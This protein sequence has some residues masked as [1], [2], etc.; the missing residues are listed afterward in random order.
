MQDRFLIDL[1][2]YDVIIGYRADDSYFSFAQDF[3]AGS[4]SLSKLKEAMYLGKLG[5]QTVFKS[6][7][8]FSHLNVIKAQ[9]VDASIYF[10]KKKNRDTKAR[11]E[12]R[13]TRSSSDSINDLFMLDIMREEIKNDDPRLR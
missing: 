4:I 12:Y 9:S 11:Y 7:I 6:K 2:P 5:E 1:N 3:V 10:E 8:S 13:K